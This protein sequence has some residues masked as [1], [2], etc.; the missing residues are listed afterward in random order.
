MST[1][2]SSDRST[3]RRK[4]SNERLVTPS[5]TRR[6]DP[7]P[8]R[9]GPAAKPRQATPTRERQ[10][11]P[12][13]CRKNGPRRAGSSSGRMVH[14]WPYFD[15]DANPGGATPMMRCGRPS[16][17][18]VRPVKPGSACRRRSQNVWPTTAVAGAPGR[19]SPSCHI[20]PR[21]AVTPSASKNGGA[22]GAIPGERSTRACARGLVA[23]VPRLLCLGID[24]G[25][26]RSVSTH[27][28]PSSCVCVREPAQ[29]SLRRRGWRAPQ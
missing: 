28:S 8:Q 11:R 18:I 12:S 27:A 25:P 1:T 6:W 15:G 10:S 16:T 22:R 26:I 21:A 13:P 19:S 3:S 2:R 14:T 4:S 9:A 29:L 20:R 23:P 24:S 17:S 7:L 5:A